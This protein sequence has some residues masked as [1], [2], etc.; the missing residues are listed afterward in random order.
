MPR[1]PGAQKA[2]GLAGHGPF[3]RGQML[4]AESASSRLA[5]QV[6]TADAADDDLQP[7]V[8]AVD[9]EQQASLTSLTGLAG[10]I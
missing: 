8:R 2:H 3:L 5:R 6:G 10:V 4:H 9:G 7:L 1:M